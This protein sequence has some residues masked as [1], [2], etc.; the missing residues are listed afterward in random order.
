[1]AEYAT[2]EGLFV[3]GNFKEAQ[4]HATRAQERLKNGSPAWLRAGDIIAYKPPSSR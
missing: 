2:A 4:I 3:Q 1:M